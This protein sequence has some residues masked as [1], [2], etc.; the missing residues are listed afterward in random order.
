MGK[1]IL[2]LAALTALLFGLALGNSANAALVSYW[3]LN[4]D[5]VASPGY[6]QDGAMVNN[7]VPAQ[8]R[9]LADNQALAFDGTQLQYVEVADGGG[10]DGAYV[11][12]ISMW[13]KWNGIQ[14]GDPHGWNY[15]GAVMGRQSDTGFSNNLIAIGGDDPAAAGVKWGSAGAAGPALEGATAVVDGL[16]R[17]VAVAFQP[18]FTG[19]SELFLDGESQGTVSAEALSQSYGSV[20]PLTLGAWID[21]GQSFS[22]ATMDDVA[23]FDDMLS[24]DQINELYLGTKT[25]LTVG[26]GTDVQVPLRGVVATASSAFDDRYA[27]QTADGVGRDTTTPSSHGFKG[28]PHGMWLTNG[29]L[30]A[31]NDLDPEITYDL[32]AVT[33]LSKMVVYNY[34]EVNYSARGVNVAQI[35]YSD[36]G[37]AWNLFGTVDLDMAPGSSPN[38]P[39]EVNL[40]GLSARYVKFDVDMDYQQGDFDFA[41]LSEVDFY[42]VPE[43]SVVALLL[44]S[45]V[46]LLPAL[47]R[48]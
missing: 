15:W 26:E 24:A 41:G 32:G 21:A 36:D 34:N 38:P 30:V 2:C 17:H 7:P 25:P 5:A 46:L 22:T 29:S 10:L 31:P 9:Y 44:G 11:G 18:H 6:G 43:P 19:L 14:D 13:V 12:T 42:V 20:V 37:A 28:H 45:L 47:R 27:D 16:W 3:P 35:Y 40:G 8:D 48:K 1:R 39:Q 4:G 23:I 33:E